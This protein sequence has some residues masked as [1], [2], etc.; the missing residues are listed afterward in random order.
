MLSPDRAGFL[1]LG[2]TEREWHAA[3]DK[4][5]FDTF[6]FLGWALGQIAAG[7]SA[8]WAALP[9]D[10]HPGVRAAVFF[11]G[12]V[13]ALKILRS[14]V[15]VGRFVLAWP[16][17]L[18]ALWLLK[19][20]SPF[21]QS[22]WA[23]RADLRKAGMTKRGGL[24]LG[25]WRSLFRRADLYRHG[26]GHLLTIGGSG[27][28]K[29]TSV[30]IPALLEAR[31]GSFIVI[32]PKAQLAAMT[33]RYRAT[34]G[35]VLHLNP[36]ADELAL[37][38]GVALPDSGFNPLSVLSKGYNLKDDAEN[39]ARLLMVTD[40]AGSESYWGDEAA[41]LIAVLL[42]WQVLREPKDRRTLAVL[43]RMLRED[44]EAIRQ[45]FEWCLTVKES[46]YLQEEARKF[47]QLSQT[48]GQWQG[49]ISK[50][51][52]ATQRY[53]PDTPL[54]D[55]TARDGLDLSR[56]KRE[57][58]TVY[59]MVPTGRAKVASPWLNLVM[60]SI[61]LAIGKPGLARPVFMLMDEAPALGYLPDLRNHLRETR[62]AGLRAWIFSQ[63]R[64]ALANPDLY[65]ENGF[66]DIM[67]LCETRSF[68]SVGDRTLATEISAML[69]EKTA[70]NRSSR[71][72]SS[73]DNYSTVGVPLMRPEEIMR[74]KKGR[75]LIIRSGMRPITA[76]LVP[77]W[78]RSSWSALVDPNP[79]R[80]Q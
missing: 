18:V 35:A 2:V 5:L 79:Y 75:Q 12:I 69:G 37:Q 17:R 6:S 14:S 58:I 45:R 52:L 20:R 53:A 54:G 44:L 22:D 24:F 30:V 1:G 16:L 57:D 10:W 63:T 42:V 39:L 4:V 56:L 36:F 40:R 38:T 72:G 23:S 65:G 47:L 19:L 33:G 28:G 34:K 46:V 50:A 48:E 29:T 78:T 13:L 73:G 80:K 49:V 43:W 26:E 51:Q 59:L 3:V 32:D 9:P 31:E 67:A 62:E 76:R 77:Y 15:A 27:A 21:G 61:G 60:G 74:M 70:V 64:A 25:Q 8:A 68:F 55:H 41:G 7:F 11:V 66:A 71:D